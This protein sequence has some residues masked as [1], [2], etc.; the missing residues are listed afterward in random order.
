MK[1]KAFCYK[2]PSNHQLMQHEEFKNL[3][4]TI[5]VLKKEGIQKS[6]FVPESSFESVSISNMSING[7]PNQVEVNLNATV[8][9]LCT[10][11]NELISF[12]SQ[13]FANDIWEVLTETR[14]LTPFCYP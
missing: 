14:P 9:G 10:Q 4:E 12:N 5:Y 2:L 7:K 13:N 8:K 1:I 3:K 11:S 6:V